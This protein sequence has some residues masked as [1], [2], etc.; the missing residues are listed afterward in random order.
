MVDKPQ[1]TV[2]FLGAGASN[3]SAF[4]L[5]TMGEFFKDADFTKYCNLKQFIDKKFTGLPI[6]KLNLE[7][8][9]TTIELS[10]DTFGT[11]GKHPEPY[12]YEARIELNEYVTAK[13]N[14]DTTKPCRLHEKIINAEL[15]GENSV[16]SIITLNYDLVVDSTLYAKS[17]RNNGDKYL[18][19]GCLLD[20][21]YG[22]SGRTE[23]IDGERASL[24]HEDTK[25][26]FYLKLHGS[27][28]WLY[29]PTSTCGNHQLFFPN[30][31]G[32]ESVHNRPGDLCSLC[33]SSLVTVIVPP[34]MYK[35]FEKFPKLG[36]LWSLAYRELNITDRIVIFGVSF[37]PSDYYLR[38]LFKKAITD[39]ENKPTIIDIDENS[40]VCDKIKEFTGVNSKHFPTLDEYLDKAS[41]FQP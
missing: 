35:T 9:V 38:W 2:Y 12:V 20:R 32:S 34:T 37:A 8:I 5:P 14:I 13:L 29:C 27:V 36:L 40:K 3:A 25:L 30:W 15:A 28:D 10:L 4:K 33:G 26:G 7:E 31:M 11:L 24:Y 19:H 6:E 18:K 22:L 23:L 17:P 41:G 16:N 1:K 21:M 39:R